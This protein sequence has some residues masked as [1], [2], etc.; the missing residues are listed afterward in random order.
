MVS[1]LEA[2]INEFRDAFSVGLISPFRAQVEYLQARIDDTFDALTRER[3]NMIVGTAHE[4][5][6]EERDVVLF[7][8]C[9]DEESPGGSLAFLSRSDVLNV[10]ITRARN[11]QLIFLS[12][13]PERISSDTLFG[14][15]LDW[16][17]SPVLQSASPASSNM[18]PEGLPEGLS[19]QLQEG[20]A[21]T[22]TH[23]GTTME[24]NV[25]VGRL[26]LDAV[27]H[28]GDSVLGIDYM[29]GTAQAPF[30]LEDHAML[31]RIGV[32]VLPMTQEGWQEQTE[33]LTALI[34]KAI[35]D[36]EV[37]SHQESG[38]E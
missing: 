18:L 34:D 2:M 11:K 22:I 12:R 13:S 37:K 4:L 35:F 20:L 5:Q 17:A 25:E 1:T 10:G 32:Q 29:D 6:G 14:Q 15:Y 38:D 9:V 24:H 7:S 8:C 31:A 36:K 30:E 3:Y 28:S 21:S 23:P 19:E 16:I 33:T 26:V 27:F